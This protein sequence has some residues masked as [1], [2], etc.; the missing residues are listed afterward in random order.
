MVNGSRSV[1][2]RSQFPNTQFPIFGRNRPNRL[3]RLA[4][5]DNPFPYSSSP[6]LTTHPFFVDFPTTFLQLKS[7]FTFPGAVPISLSG[8][9]P[10]DSLS[11][12]SQLC[13]C[14]E[15]LFPCPCEKRQRRSNLNSCF[16]SFAMMLRAHVDSFKRWNA[17]V[18]TGRDS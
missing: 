1:A 5:H 10:L 17:Q 6:H 9:G 15:L 2:A 3:D 16:T 14:E 11:I 7:Y 18:K 8:E 4:A 12:A 13:H